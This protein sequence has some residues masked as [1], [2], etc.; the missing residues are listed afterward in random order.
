M[1]H[2]PETLHDLDRILTALREA[3]P[4]PGIDQRILARLQQ[5]EA[6][7]ALP[8][9]SFSRLLFPVCAALTICIAFALHH[10]Q[11]NIAQL[12]QANKLETGSPQLKAGPDLSTL[13]TPQLT[14]QN[15]KLKTGPDL[16]LVHAHNTQ[17]SAENPPSPHTT[18]P[19]CD[20]DP[21]A[22]ADTQAPSHPAPA[23]PLTT[24][25]KLML[26]MVRRESPVLVAELDTRTRE[27][28][29]TRERDEVRQLLSALVPEIS[30]APTP[31]PAPETSVDPAGP[32]SA[33]S[34]ADLS[35]TSPSTN[36]DAQ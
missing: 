28:S 31:A 29:L 33:S 3:Q 24:Q 21:T 27:A 32:Q 10:T 35:S 36:G 23:M 5:R 19:L 1:N 18:D 2:E 12:P 30:Q 11:R 6:E 34:A 22:L 26:R 15:S 17:T 9:W 4:R 16:P 25:E 8:R 20:C 7:P 14:T 13:H